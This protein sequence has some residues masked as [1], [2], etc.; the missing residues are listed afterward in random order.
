MMLLISFSVTYN[1]NIFLEWQDLE[2]AI[3]YFSVI[4][5]GAPRQHVWNTAKYIYF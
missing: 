4:R 2:A 3:Y 5:V 1:V